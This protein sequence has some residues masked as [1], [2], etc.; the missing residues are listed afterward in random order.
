[1]TPYVIGSGRSADA[2]KKCAAMLS[3]THSLAEPVQL[4]RGEALPRVNADSKSVLIIANPHGLHAPSI[5]AGLDAGFQGFLIEKPACVNLE[6]VAQLKSALLGRSVKAAVFHV[7]RQM[8][9]IQTIKQMIQ[10]GELGEIISI[11]GRYWQS[12]TAQKAIDKNA[13]PVSWK[14]D[15]KLGGAGDTFIDIGVHWADAVAF[16]MGEETFKGSAW[17]SYANAEAAHRDSHVHL[18][19]EFSNQR[20]AFGSISKTVHGAT[21]QF[22][23]V[24]LGTKRS[25]TWN[26][27]NADEIVIGEGSTRRTFPRKTSLL[28]SGL[29]PFHGMGWV[30]GYYEIMKQ[31][32]L[33]LES[34][35]EEASSGNYPHLEG[36]LKL[37]ESLF[38]LTVQRTR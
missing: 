23:V 11:E 3:Q 17:L 28:G 27:L 18:N 25:A 13:P 30:E 31:I 35:S 5:I 12:S 38:G 37:M 8:W 33:D 9:G 7:Y 34:K 10:S 2:L 16:L 29:P 26:F 36:N 20:R 21:N 6:E 1:M 24:V 19:L 15:V 32:I 22:E 4:K 14:N